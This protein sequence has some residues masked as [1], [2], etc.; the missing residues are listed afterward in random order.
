MSRKSLGHAVE[1]HLW[2]PGFTAFGGGVAAFS[3]E[4]ALAVSNETTVRLAGKLDVGGTWH[5]LPLQ[6]SGRVTPRLRTMHF[7]TSLIASALRRRPGL[8]ISA[9]VNF[10]PVAQALRRALGTPFALT[11]YGVD[12]NEHLSG[13]RLRALRTADS[14]WSISQWTT[15][16]LLARGV[17]EA[18]VR[19]VPVTVADDRFTIGAAPAELRERHSIGDDERVVLTIARL[20]AS[21]GYKGCDRLMEALPAVS[22]AVGRVRYLVVGRGDDLPR[23]QAVSAGLRFDGHVTFCGFVSDEDLPGYYRLAD[24]FAMPSAGEGFGIVFLEA[25]A[26]GKPV[27]GGNRDGTCDALADGELG[28]LVDPHSVDAIADGLV[29]LLLR[30]GPALWFDPPRLRGRCLELYGRNAFR[31]RVREALQS[32]ERGESN[33][34]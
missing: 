11:A 9:H 8:I 25:M 2:A 32:L 20:D 29:R 6:G 15:Q 21:E 31:S 26:C 14:V 23:L 13:A 17:P 18:R 22:R 3:R 30:R 34:R 5:G 1:T 27:L 10:G 24:A 33:A 12:V 4:L 7:T 16:R 19:R 28:L